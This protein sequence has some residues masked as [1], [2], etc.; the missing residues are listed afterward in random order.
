M[1]YGV[2]VTGHPALCGQELTVLLMESCGPLALGAAF[3]HVSVYQCRSEL[4]AQVWESSRL[5]AA[6]LLH[7]A[8]LHG[9]VWRL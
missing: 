9:S 6:F 4:R 5:P 2:V 3:Q 1:G 7:G 8:A